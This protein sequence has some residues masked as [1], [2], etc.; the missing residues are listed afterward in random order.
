MG[1]VWGW[2][3][4]AVYIRRASRIRTNSH[5]VANTAAPCAL[6]ISSP[7]LT[8]K[9]PAAGGTSLFA[10]L[11][12]ETDIQDR[13][14]SRYSQ[15][16]GAGWCSRRAIARRDIASHAT[17]GATPSASAPASHPQYA[18]SSNYPN[19]AT[20]APPPARASLYSFLLSRGFRFVAGV[21]H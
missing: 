18:L 19:C 15:L 3:R 10:G 2:G 13:C 8:G 17:L 21:R 14:I 7:P 12:V 5:W 6:G 20:S 1:K 16:G 4:W 9:L 11:D